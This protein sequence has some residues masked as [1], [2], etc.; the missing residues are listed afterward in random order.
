MKLTNYQQI[1]HSDD[2]N[3]GQYYMLDDIEYNNTIR[4]TRKHK[5]SDPCIDLSHNNLPSPPIIIRVAWCIG[6][7]CIGIASYCVI[8]I[9]S[10]P[11][12]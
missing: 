1:E 11:Y 8:F 10:I 5:L 12:W 7:S 9:Y 6:I 3:Y 4:Q 2:D